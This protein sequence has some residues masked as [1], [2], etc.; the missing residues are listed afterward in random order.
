MFLHV[1]VILFTGG[2]APLHAGIHPRDQRQTP[3]GPEAGTPLPP[4]PE[5]GTP[6]PLQCIL[7]DTGNTRA[8]RILLEC[9]LVIICILVSV[10]RYK[11]SCN[12]DFECNHVFLQ[13][14]RSR[15]HC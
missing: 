11:V 7:G 1:S 6:P 2:S 8:V 15:A 14:L 10:G 13:S 4:G 3:P 5:A 9:N 12:H